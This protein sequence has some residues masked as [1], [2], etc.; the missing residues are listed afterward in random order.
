MDYYQ[1]VKRYYNYI[2]LDGTRMYSKEK[3]SKFVEL[4]VITKEQFKEITNE[5]FD[6]GFILENNT[7]NNQVM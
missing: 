6:I 7:E 4:G 5:P 3:V 2:K 1:I